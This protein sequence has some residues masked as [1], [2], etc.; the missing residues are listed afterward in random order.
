VVVGGGAPAVVVVV[1]PLPLPL[2]WWCLCCRRPRCGGGGRAPP[3]WLVVVPPLPPSPLPLSLAWRRW[4]RGGEDELKKKTGGGGL[5]LSPRQPSSPRGRRWC[6]WCVVAHR[7]G[8]GALALV[9]GVVGASS[10]RWCVG[11]GG[12]G[13]RHGRCGRG[14]YAVA[15]RRGGGGARHGRRG[16][17]W[18]VVAHPRGGGALARAEVVLVVGVIGVVAACRRGGGALARAVVRNRQWVAAVGRCGGGRGDEQGDEWGR[19]A[20][21]ILGCAFMYV[22]NGITLYSFLHSISHLVM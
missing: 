22:Q 6:C 11:T 17:G 3:L 16:R 14:W 13:A 8:G 5:P 21:A 18:C 20:P 7:R 19:A 15:R 2:W 1:T 12:G 4:C 10:W 9:V